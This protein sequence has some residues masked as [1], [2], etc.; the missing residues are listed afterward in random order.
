MP[1]RGRIHRRA[2]E[3]RDRYWGDELFFKF[4]NTLQSS[5]Q[6]HVEQAL[7]EYFPSQKSRFAS[8]HS[9]RKYDRPQPVLN[10]QLWE[11]SRMWTVQHFQV[12]MA[13][14]RLTSPAIYAWSL[15]PWTTPGF[16]FVWTWPTKAQALQD[17]KFWDFYE[18]Y[19]A[20]DFEWDVLWGS[21]VK[22]DELRPP[23]KIVL[24]ELR[25]FLS[26]PIHHNIALGEMCA[27]MNDR[28]KNST[29]TWSTL[30][31]SNFNREWHDT[32]SS[33]KHPHFFGADLSNQDA[34]MFREAMLDQ[35]GIRFE[36]L[37]RD[38][39]T[40][41]NWKRM[42]NLY[43]QIVYSLIVLAQGEVVEKDTGNPSGSGNTITDNTMILF[44]CYAYCWLLL[45]LEKYNSFEVFQFQD[46]F[47]YSTYMKHVIARI[48]GDD[49]LLNISD[50]ALAVF[51]IRAIVRAM[52][53][54]FIVLKPENDEPLADFQEL[55]FCSHTTKTYFGTYVPVMEY[56]RGVASLGWK[57]ASLL[58]RAGA[59]VNDPSVHYTL[60]RALD[61]RR[62]GFWNDRLFALADA[63]VRWIL[64][65]Y[66]P[67]LSKPAANGP[68]AGKP[69]E[70]ILA[71][72][73]SE[74]ALIYLYT[75]KESVVKQCA[76]ASGRSPQ[77]RVERQFQLCVFGISMPPKQTKKF[78]ERFHDAVVEPLE[79][80]ADSITRAPVR[81][82]NKIA[83]TK[84]DPLGTAF[85]KQ[86][87]AE[88]D[89]KMSSSG[90]KKAHSKK[91]RKSRKG[92]KKK[93]SV[94][95]ATAIISGQARNVSSARRRRAFQK[96]NK[97][98]GKSKAPAA[99]LGV[100]G[101][102]PRNIRL[103]TS[104]GLTMK[105]GV[106]SGVTELTPDLTVS[107]TEDIAGTVLITLPINALA[108]A[109]SSRFSTFAAN[110]DEYC[111]EELQVCLEPDMPYTD[112]IMIGGG[113]EHDPLD[114]IPAP[115]GII[116]VAKYMEHQNF[117]AESLLKSTKT[118]A[119]FPQDKRAVVKGARGPK[120]GM[121]FNRL[122]SPGG[123][124]DLTTIQQGTII[125]FVHT[126]DQGSL[127]GGTIHLGPVL[128]RWKCRFREAAERMEHVA[129]EDAHHQASTV[130]IT[131]PMIW[132]TASAAGPVVQPTLLPGSTMEIATGGT[133]GALYAA[134][135]PGFYE[136][137]FF[138]EVSAAG[139]GAY[140][141]LAT[142]AS[143][144][145]FTKLSSDAIVTT[146][147]VVTHMAGYSRFQITGPASTY[148][149][150]SV[151]VFRLFGSTGTATGWTLQDAKFWIR[152]IPYGM[153]QMLLHK[154]ISVRGL[155]WTHMREQMSKQAQLASQVARALQAHGVE[156]KDPGEDA[157]KKLHKRV[158]L[159]LARTP[160]TSRK[161]REEI[162][163]CDSDEDTKSEAGYEL[164]LA[165]GPQLRAP[166]RGAPGR[167]YAQEVK[168]GVRQ[169]TLAEDAK[170]ESKKKED[171]KPVPPDVSAISKLLSSGWSLVKSESAAAAPT[172]TAPAR[173]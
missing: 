95:K 92:S 36:M 10:R 73:L 152:P 35:A 110:Y 48:I 101:A 58:H 171:E 65:E 112:S 111:F 64:E 147:S 2:K 79:A 68:I 155:A 118:G 122:P 161:Y 20:S 138:F 55:S 148:T 38:L 88:T 139:T 45:W 130:S 70:D 47:R 127:S 43:I 156:A 169:P 98:I 123:N 108:I 117:H 157:E 9:T 21:T 25:T 137:R 97:S 90:K 87:F 151:G 104:A 18:Q 74:Q 4:V 46:E 135:N 17:E 89:S 54:L 150:G 160:R 170:E 37:G 15:R 14:A 142:A 19:K 149:L 126:A 75:G 50:H 30:G 154:N 134:L 72:Y 60:Q 158:L 136:A 144:T 49:S 39:Q 11:I 85:H 77:K 114:D 40:E 16:P 69:L 105:G 76:G 41:Q 61:I 59:E 33:F 128:L 119:K 23:E 168:A 1:W 28:L 27:D 173:A 80:A 13:G 51:H 141:W 44:R 143:Q 165:A 164:E 31:R 53:S 153:T 124:A 12:A 113:I 116:D 62:E 159:E 63:F 162:Y 99:M 82:I 93:M 22:S 3:P 52:W 106:I 5:E 6:E 96:F 109:P 133:S 57:G 121:Y 78:S 145:N 84:L 125:V 120:S 29:A 132:N 100:R 146:A 81:V 103:S 8:Y 83:G 56:S 94:G 167:M 115:G 140:Y 172:T 107:T 67:L 71:S 102:R 7:Q 26:S 131:D 24:S 34:S 166:I 91:K 66:A 86:V 42:S 129:S 32:M 163:D